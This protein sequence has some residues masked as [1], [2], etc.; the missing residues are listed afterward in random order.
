MID[1]GRINDRRC[2]ESGYGD[3]LSRIGRRIALP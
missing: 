2:K 3:C 1:G